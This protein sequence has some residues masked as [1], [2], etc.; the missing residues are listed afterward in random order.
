MAKYFALGPLV[1]VLCLALSTSP[2]LS[3]TTDNATSPSPPL[4]PEDKISEVKATSPSPTL[5]PEDKIS[6]KGSAD[7]NTTTTTNQMQTIPQPTP[8]PAPAV[9]TDPVTGSNVTLTNS[10]DP[11]ASIPEGNADMH[12]IL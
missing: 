7:S 5:T 6:E 8:Q 11:P 9:S 3:D 12:L 4:N 1:L 2:S 10:S